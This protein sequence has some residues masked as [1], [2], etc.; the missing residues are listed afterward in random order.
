MAGADGGPRRRTGRD[1]REP[2]LGLQGAEAE[3]PGHILETIQARSASLTALGVQADVRTQPPLHQLAG[4]KKRPTLL[5]LSR[6]KMRL[7][8]RGPDGEPARSAAGPG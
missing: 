7:V 8:C 1:L 6:R 4:S 5:L 2:D 3:I